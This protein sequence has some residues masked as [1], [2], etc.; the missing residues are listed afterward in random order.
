ME[1]WEWVLVVVAAALAALALHDVLQRRHA[2][3]HNFPIVGHLRY[4]LEGVGPELRQYI[5]T[6]NDADKPFSRDQRRW[7][8]TGAKKLNTYFGYGTDNDLEQ[9]PSYLIVKQTSFPLEEA[10]PGSDGGPPG[11]TLPCAKVLGG[12]RDRARAFR[13]PSAV[14]ISGMSYGSLS[15]AAVESLNRGAA[16]AGCSQGTGEGGLT[17]HHRHG[18]SLVWQ[19]ATGYFGCRDAQGHF[20]LA[21]FTDVVAETPNLCA[22]EV[23]LSQGAKPGIGGVLPGAK[24]TPEIARIRGIPV[25]VDCISPARHTAFHDADSLLDFV[26]QLADVS[27]LPVGIKSAVGDEGFFVELARLM[28]SGERGIDFVVVD[29][30]EG[31]TGA[32]PLTFTDHVA[33]PFKLGFSRVFRAFVEEGVA[34]RVVF[35]GSGKLGLPEQGLLAFALGCDAINVGREAM[36]SIG[37]IQAQRC[38]T[39]RCPTGVTT[40]SRWLMKGLDPDLKSVRAAS[41]IVQLRKE[42]LQLSHACGAVHPAL[43]TLDHLEIIGEHFDARPAREVFGYERGWG[44][45]STEDR[46]AIV[47]L[48]T[49]PSSTTSD[50]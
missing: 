47:S 42:L 24:V 43:V 32:G 15:A 18:G 35:V 13:M 2:V 1:W 31:G 17:A 21:R 4:L 38:H 6:D 20:D 40:N 5:V 22:I 23:K 8:Y 16:L 33:L 11:Y 28:R 19:I 25:G 45:P 34:P 41:Y 3:L 49:Q 14:N 26:E 44:L 37:C 29:G 9:S 7:I 39:G 46:D 12:P 10:L 27:G 30:G 50:R 48:M 36:L